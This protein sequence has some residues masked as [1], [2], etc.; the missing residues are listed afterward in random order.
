MAKNVKRRFHERCLDFIEKH[1]RLGWY[2]AT[3]A[4]FNMVL[5]ILDL[6]L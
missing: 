2:I 4:T 6:F 3:I 5:N 1:P